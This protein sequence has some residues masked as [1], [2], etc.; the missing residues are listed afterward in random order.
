MWTALDDESLGLSTEQLGEARE[1]LAGA[2]L[3]S[4]SGIEA[5]TRTLTD[6][7]IDV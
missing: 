1:A 3:F 4:I 2:D 6:L 5:L 7:G